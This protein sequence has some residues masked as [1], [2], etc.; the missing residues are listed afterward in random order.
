MFRLETSDSP[1]TPV[2]QVHGPLDYA[3]VGRMDE[4]VIALL[5]RSRSAHLLIDLTHSQLVDSAG[6]GI[7]VKCHKSCEARGGRLKVSGAND[8][9]AK[10]LGVTHLSGVFEIYDDLASGVASFETG[11]KS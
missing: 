3:S 11:S 2:I 10:L 1:D 5:E 6:L 7:L 8:K 9:I 4:A